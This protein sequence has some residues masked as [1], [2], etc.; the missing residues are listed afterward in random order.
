[1]DREVWQATVHRVT[2]NLTECAKALKFVFFVS[3]AFVSRLFLKHFP[4]CLNA[5][6]KSFKIKKSAKTQNCAS[7]YHSEE[8]TINICYEYIYKQ[9]TINIMRFYFVCFNSHILTSCIVSISSIH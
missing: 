7:A 2:K 8:M 3:W 9:I 4:E 6:L 1:M 5:W